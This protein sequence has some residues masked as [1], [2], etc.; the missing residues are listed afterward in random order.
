MDGAPDCE[1]LPVKASGKQKHVSQG[2]LLCRGDMQT[3][4]A[5]VNRSSLNKEEK[6]SP[7]PKAAR[8]RGS[9][10][11]YSCRKA[12]LEDQGQLGAHEI[13]TTSWPPLLSS[14]RPQFHRQSVLLGP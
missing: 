8:H 9:L 4:F 6:P 5:G 12:P 13:W 3:G 10:H 11:S 7:I 2:R 14:P 1:E